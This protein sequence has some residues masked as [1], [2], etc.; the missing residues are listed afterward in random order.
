[1]AKFHIIKASIFAVVL[2]FPSWA[3]DI[4][5]ETVVATVD[6]TDITIGHMI[7]LLDDLP[8]QYKNLPDDVLFDGIKEQLIQQTL[9][10][11]AYEG[12]NEAIELRLDNE[13]RS[14]KASAA[15]SI[16]MQERVNDAALQA[17]YDERFANAAPQ[18]EYNASHILV[19]TEQEALDL[20]AKLDDGAEFAALAQEFSTGPSGP[21]GGQLGWFGAGMMVAPFEEAVV[22]MEPETISAPVETQFGWHVIRLNERRVLGVPTL[23]DVRADLT[24]ELSQVAIE[25]EINELLDG[26]SVDEVDTSGIDPSV[27]RNIDLVLQ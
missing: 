3:Q 6:G 23:D 10:A 17:L 26:A 14:L 19:E 4:S 9:L 15:I 8:E 22:A 21:N 5:A 1:M 13:E 18:E 25:D 20:I 16:A 7:L 2:G 27:L 24:D 12:S 11:N